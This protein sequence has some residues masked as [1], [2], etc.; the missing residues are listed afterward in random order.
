[1]KV[2]DLHPTCWVTWRRLEK[3]LLLAG[4][5]RWGVVRQLVEADGDEW[6]AQKAWAAALQME[7][8]QAGRQVSHPQIEGELSPGATQQLQQSY[9]KEKPDCFSIARR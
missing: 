7:S 1:M 9:L 6:P 5:W 4:E 2:S 8:G 3:C